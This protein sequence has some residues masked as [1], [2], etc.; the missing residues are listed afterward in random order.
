M[1][2]RTLSHGCHTIVSMLKSP[3]SNNRLKSL[4]RHIRDRT[5]VPA[6]LP[7][8]QEVMLWYNDVAA[9]VQ[10]SIEALDWKPLLGDRPYEVTS[11]SKTIDTLRQKLQRD[12]STPLPSVQDVAGVR[13]EAEMSLD[14]QDAVAHAVAGLYDHTP[15]SIKDLRSDPHSGYRAVHVWLRLPVR[16]E[17]QVRT[18]VQSAW[19]NAYEAA[20]DVFGRTIR[21]AGR[22]EDPVARQLV[23]ALQ[24]LSVD[25]I[26]A[27]EVER[28]SRARELLRLREYADAG[29]PI[30]DQQVHDRLEAEWGLR[31]QAELDLR[32]DLRQ[33]HDQFRAIQGR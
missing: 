12:P 27:M 20:A 1:G 19:A 13:F 10:R 32:D 26:A 30:F 28:N 7:Q 17:V 25:R 31:R 18:H 21:Y 4:S 3:W 23:D 2:T 5:P 15:S 9:D 14:E 16:V 6:E 8:Y 33:I 11:R 22:P 29:S 24:S